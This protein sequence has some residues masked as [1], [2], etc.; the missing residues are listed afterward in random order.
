MSEV[1]APEK[2]AAAESKSVAVM[3]QYATVPAESPVFNSLKTPVIHSAPSAH[4]GIVLKE[5]AL[6]GHLILRGNAEDSS[7]VAG[8]SKVL[9]MPLPTEPLTSQESNG[10]A[11]SWLSPDEWLILLPA[12]FTYELEVKLR[13]QLTGHFA[14]I[15]QSGGQTIFELSGDEVLNV[16]KKST[17][18]DIHPKEYPVG[19]VSTSK[20][21]KSSAIFRKVSEDKWQLVVRRSFSDYI[22]R[23]LVDASKE[24]GLVIEK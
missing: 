5:V 3:D 14:I 20:L 19:K 8:V 16:L 13:A 10:V 21:A 9:N 2:V 1:I 22:W 4:F 24:Y 6:M 15:N 7:F 11:V 23:W 18:L 17:H 12:E